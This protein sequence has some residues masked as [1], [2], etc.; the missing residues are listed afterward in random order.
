MK[1]CDKLIAR[2][3]FILKSVFKNAAIIALAIT[4]S[5]TSCKKNDDLTDPSSN[6]NNGNS[7]S[8]NGKIDN[9][10]LILVEGGSFIM[11]SPAGVGEGDE[12]PQHKV[13]LSSYQI[14]KYEITN[15][16]YAKFLTAKGNQKE[17]GVL[18]YQGSDFDINGK[19]YTPKKGK[20]NLPIRFITW[21]GA[22]AYAEWVGG[23]I[24]T[25]AEWE[26][27]ARGG[28]HSKGYTYSGSN[29][30]DEVAWYV[31]NSGGRLHNVGEKKPNE[32]GLYDMSGNVWEWTA[33]WY[34]SYTKEDKTNPKGADTG[35]VRVR[36]GASAFCVLKNI[37][38]AN[39]SNRDPNGVRHNMGFRVVFDVK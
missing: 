12:R 28:K 37:R 27:A 11:G 2:Q 33:D 21:H 22:K 16:E 38:S 36:R 31:G 4:L 24:P 35:T 1:K 7:S 23:R 13:T 19:T 26:Y 39:R 30:M 34:G 20:E 17:A 10:N 32:L 18:W 9:S 15:T 8:T 25:E 3:N 14:T 29:N 5:L 6:S